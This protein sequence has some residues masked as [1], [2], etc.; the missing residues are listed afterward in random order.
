MPDEKEIKELTINI[1]SYKKK[2]DK[3]VVDGEKGIKQAESIKKQAS[4]LKSLAISTTE[5]EEEE[6]KIAYT[7]SRADT[8]KKKKEYDTIKDRRLS[9]VK[10]C[11]SIF[12]GA[13]TKIEDF[14]AECVRIAEEKRQAEEEAERATRAEEQRKAQEEEREAQEKAEKE[15]VIEVEEITGDG[16]GEE[17]KAQCY[18]GKYPDENCDR[19]GRW[20][21]IETTPTEP[22]HSAPLGTI[23]PETPHPPQKTIKEGNRLITCE[24]D[25]EITNFKLLVGDC[26]MGRG[27]AC[28]DFLSP[29]MEAI[30][31]HIRNGGN[32][33]SGCEVVE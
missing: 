20:G 27:G 10:A 7:E 9:L 16:E 3:L 26:I 15:K 17:V 28:L 18:H 31:E 30:T 13:K 14:R 1:D 32:V 11:K 29:N 6:K 4:N 23:T 12:D 21:N 22:N 25:I 19:C 5:I 33:P 8:E 2:L 24:I